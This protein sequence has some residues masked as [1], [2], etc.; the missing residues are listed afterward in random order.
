MRPVALAFLAII[1]L[2]ALACTCPLPQVMTCFPSDLF[3]MSISSISMGIAWVEAVF[4]SEGNSAKC[5]FL[6]T[7]LRRC[8]EGFCSFM[9]PEL[10][11]C[12]LPKQTPG[13][14]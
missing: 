14:S 1:A 5:T 13:V 9:L 4:T 12:R 8:D 3:S 7:G 10:T 6:D 2:A 11:H